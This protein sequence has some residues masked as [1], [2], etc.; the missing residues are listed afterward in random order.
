M[1]RRFLAVILIIVVLITGGCTIATPKFMQKE[2]PVSNLPADAILSQQD[3]IYNRTIALLNSAK[4]TIYVEQA[5]FDDAQ[6]LDLLIKKAGSGVEV[7]VLLDQFRKENAATLNQL[8]NHD[9][10]AQ[11]YPALKG[12]SNNVKLL[13]VD[14]Q[15]ALVYGPAWTQEGRSVRDLAVELTGYAAWK[16]SA[17]F[18]R[19]WEFTTT[20]TLDIPKT[21]PAPSDHIILATNAKV[22]QQLQNLIARSSGSIW[23][24]VT[25]LK[26]EDIIQ[27]LADAKQK[28]REVRLLLNK[29][30]ALKE[31]VQPI[32]S[33][34]KSAG[35]DI[36][37]L[38][39]NSN[40][41]LGIFDGST[42]FFSSSGWTYST[43]VINHEFSITV[44]SPQAAAKLSNLF[45][46]DWANATAEL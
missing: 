37:Y 25:E 33:L 3:D 45:S 35:V 14:H 38:P 27:A 6:L 30:Y 4:T 19:D 15:F 36:R 22:K 11:F 21:S 2:T 40:L 13:V 20:L 29:E 46:Q 44:P 39:D 12:Q 1:F 23:L 17:V 24:E 41:R 18:A 31:D 8:K 32:L 42:F 26:D 34:L 5:S 28:G 9:I 16:A 7:K 10:S 43:F